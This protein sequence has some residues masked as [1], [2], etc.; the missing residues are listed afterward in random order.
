MRDQIVDFVRRWSDKTEIH[1][2]R[3]IQW[4]GIAPS[5]FYS[6]RRRYGSLNEHNGWVPRDFWLEE[7][8]KQ[9]ILD[10]YRQ[11]PLEGYRRLTFMMLDADIVAVSPSSVWRVLSRA[12]L[13]RKWNDKTSLKGTG[14]QQPLEPHQH[15][16]IDVSYINISGTF[17]YL[18]SVLDG[19]SRSIVHWG[20]R[21]AMKEADIEII[22]QAAK[23]KYP[24]ARPRLISDNGPQ[25]L[26]KDFKEFIRISGMTHVRTSP[27]YPRRTASG[28]LAQ[29]VEERM[30]SAGR[31]AD[32]GGCASADPALCRALQHGA[33]AQ[34]DRVCD[35]GDLLAGR[36]GE[37]H[38]ARDRKLEQARQQR[39]LRRRQ[40]A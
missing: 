37:I 12:G 31:A 2:G 29:I 30:Y 23:E 6:W 21:E 35:A 13:L 39:Q 27:Y 36:R 14:F 10:F 33:L 19:Y 16:H 34:R 28:A 5:K 3:F 1:A 32:A 26:A 24:D 25:F 22:L 4:L 15:W 7:W 11:H 9:A 40:A 20:L 18:C 38:A 8:E 17:Y